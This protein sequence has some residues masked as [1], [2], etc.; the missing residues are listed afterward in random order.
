MV[1]QYDDC[2]ISLSLC[3]YKY[4]RHVVHMRNR[5]LL[6]M[7]VKLKYYNMR[8]IKKVWYLLRIGLID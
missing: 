4:Y 1:L 6:F 5:P 2:S 3:Y 8:S 7:I